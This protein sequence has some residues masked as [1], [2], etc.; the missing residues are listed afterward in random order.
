MNRSLPVA[1]WACQNSITLSRVLICVA[2]GEPGKEDV[3]FAGR[4]ARHL[5]AT[6]TLLSVL[7]TDQPEAHARTERGRIALGNSEW[8]WKVPSVPQGMK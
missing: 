2:A 3:L 5:G 1:F 8:R 4:L 7:P 6:A